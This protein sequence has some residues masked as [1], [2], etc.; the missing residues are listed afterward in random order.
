MSDKDYIMLENPLH[1]NYISFEITDECK[2]NLFITLDGSILAFE[3]DYIKDVDKKSLTLSML[4]YQKDSSV[5]SKIESEDDLKK[6][7]YCMQQ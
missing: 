7:L 4:G 5:P 3:K 6:I 1:L 2:E